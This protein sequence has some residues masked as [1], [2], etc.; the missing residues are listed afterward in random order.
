M[1]SQR[2]SSAHLF[3]VHHIHWGFVGSVNI[4]VFKGVGFFYYWFGKDFQGQGFGPQAARIL[5]GW[6]AEYLSLNCCYTKVY[7]DNIYSQKALVKSGFRPLPLKIAESY[8]QEAYEEE[9][10]YYQGNNRPDKILL[11]EINQFFIDMDCENINVFFFFQLL[12]F[13]LILATL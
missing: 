1:E 13:Y 12:L 4:D 8:E 2:R 7:Q 3:A 11:A 10:I 5:L 6:S 9:Y